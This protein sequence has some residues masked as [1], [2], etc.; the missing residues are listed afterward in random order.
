MI[1]PS[2]PNNPSKLEYFQLSREFNTKWLIYRKYR[3][4]LWYWEQYE[5]IINFGKF[6]ENLIKIKQR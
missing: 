4:L 2:Q 5:E 6:D 3:N 1:Q